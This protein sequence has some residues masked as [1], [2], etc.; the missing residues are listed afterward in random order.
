MQRIKSVIG[1]LQ[2]FAVIPLLASV[3]PYGN[4]SKQCQSLAGEK[5]C[6][7]SKL[8]FI[9]ESTQ[10]LNKIIK[11]ITRIPDVIEVSRAG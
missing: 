7:V 4:Q 9:G 6:H 11:D 8:N 3:Q 5:I 10:Q 1:I 2:P